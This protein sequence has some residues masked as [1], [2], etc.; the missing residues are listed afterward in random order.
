MIFN[1]NEIIK[2]YGEDIWQYKR[3]E[4]LDLGISRENA[5]FISINGLP[6]VFSDFNFFELEKF[7]KTPFENTN[8]IK[9]GQL[10]FGVYGLFLKENEDELFTS[11]YY[12]ESNIYILNKNVETFFLFHLIKNKIAKNRIE[13][14]EF[15]SSEYALELKR[16]FN[17][18]DCVA[19]ED[20]EGYWSHL[21]EDYE[22]EL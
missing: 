16:V 22:T 3:I 11:S 6:K 14:N 4:L 15:N 5:N 19:M 7:Q 13:R 9:I 17:E 8:I 12:H 20:Q 2:Y 1:I 21:V 18:N 10:S